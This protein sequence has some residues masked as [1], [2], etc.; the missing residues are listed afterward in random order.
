ME[1]IYIGTDNKA[2]FRCPACNRSKT[3]DV[4]KYK[5]IEKAVRI[6]IKCPCG[7]TF[8]AILE[9]RK[10]FRKGMNLSGNFICKL[11]KIKGA[12]TVQ[13][14]SR[15]GIGIKLNFKND[16]EPGD[17]LILEFKLDDKRQ[18]FVKKIVTVKNVKEL[19]IGAEF[20]STEHY[21]PLGAYILFNFNR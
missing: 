11:K 12:M 18:S 5:N 4:S 6:K 7:N 9:R 19:L 3:A 14:I 10:Y 8:S 15:S 1:K 2:M 17:K 20:T 13:D 21:D 16:I